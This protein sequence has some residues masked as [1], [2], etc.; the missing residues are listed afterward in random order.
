LYD[1]Q[2]LQAVAKTDDP[3]KLAKLIGQTA[4]EFAHKREGNSPFSDGA[5]K[6]K[7]IHRPGGKVDDITVLVGRVRVDEHEGKM[8]DDDKIMAGV[9]GK[10]WAKL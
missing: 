4:S 3:T 7:G 1:N 10:L 2:I 8:S 9:L 6:A 5:Y